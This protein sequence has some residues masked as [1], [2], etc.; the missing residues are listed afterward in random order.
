M[1]VPDVAITP[2]FEIRKLGERLNTLPKST[3]IFEPN[4]DTVQSRS[5]QHGHAGIGAN[6]HLQKGSSYR[7]LRLSTVGAK[8]S[9]P[10][11]PWTDL[12]PANLYCFI[13]K[14]EINTLP[15]LTSP[16]LK[17]QYQVICCKKELGNQSPSLAACASVSPTA[18]PSA[19]QAAGT[20]RRKMWLHCLRM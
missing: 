16:A 12:V 15:L 1:N 9:G 17:N 3:Q 11:S 19:G 20:H 6:T 18:L 5:Q 10:S 14:M 13:C 7:A 2:I 4:S 8:D